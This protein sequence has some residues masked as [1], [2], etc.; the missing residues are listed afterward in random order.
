MYSLNDLMTSP[1]AEF[2]SP[3]AVLALDPRNRYRGMA[4]PHAPLLGRNAEEEWDTSKDTAA[5]IWLQV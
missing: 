5:W 1:N 4:D 3:K 2:T